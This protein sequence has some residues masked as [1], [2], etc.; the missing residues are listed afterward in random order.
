MNNCKNLPLLSKKE[1]QAHLFSKGFTKSPKIEKAF[2][3]AEQV[4][5]D[6]RRD[7]GDSYLEQHIYPVTLDV[8]LELPQQLLNED[9]IVISL[10]HDAIEDCN[11]PTRNSIF[12]AYDKS[13][14]DTLEFLAK[15][16]GWNPLADF[17]LYEPI[18]DF[19]YHHKLNHAPWQAL[20]VKVCDRF[21]NL[22]CSYAMFSKKQNIVKGK[23]FLKETEE[24]YLKLSKKLDAEIGTNTY[25]Q[26]LDLV[27]NFKE[28]IRA[29]ELKS[30]TTTSS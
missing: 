23:V 26:L 5:K 6:K 12:S 29:T 8:I 13:I 1:L 25:N 20:L 19:F 17:S 3:F 7:S 24:M 21:N 27:N 2:D 9:I 10:L 14:F 18:R 28:L 15:T 4:H 11:K 22:T 16:H 30:A